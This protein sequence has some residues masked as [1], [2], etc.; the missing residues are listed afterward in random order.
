MVVIFCEINDISTFAV[1]QLVKI[2][3]FCC[4]NNR[5]EPANK[6]SFYALVLLAIVRLLLCM[7]PYCVGVLEDCSVSEVGTKR[8]LRHQ[9]HVPS[10]VSQFEMD[11]YR[12]RSAT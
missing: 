10:R 4:E 9:Q 2:L 5:F 8:R 3:L 12:F 6:V 7:S 1:V 11:N